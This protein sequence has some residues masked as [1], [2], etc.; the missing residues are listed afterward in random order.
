[1][2]NRFP[3]RFQVNHVGPKQ[4]KS[5]YPPSIWKW[6]TSST[7]SGPVS[8]LLSGDPVSTNAVSLT[9]GWPEGIFPQ[10]SHWTSGIP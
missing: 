7:T 9:Q 3:G 1:M 4:F 8:L 5:P 6:L 10:L 2:F